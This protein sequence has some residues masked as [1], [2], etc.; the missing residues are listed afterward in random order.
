MRR[1]SFGGNG[2][3]QYGEAGFGRE[4]PAESTE[5]P[6]EMVGGVALG[7]R[8][9]DGRARWRLATMVERLCAA[10][11]LI[12]YR[13][14]NAA[15]SQISLGNFVLLR[16]LGLNHVRCFGNRHTTRVDFI[17]R[18]RV[19]YPSFTNRSTRP[20]KSARRSVGS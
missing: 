20:R 4:K 5:L 13:D 6:F 3:A 18:L 11:E 15:S 2:A 1:D 9:L 19:K 7:N 17:V 10:A 16:R 12:C 14:G 8:V